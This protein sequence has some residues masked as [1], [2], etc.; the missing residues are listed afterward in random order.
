MILWYQG[1]VYPPL[2]SGREL[3]LGPVSVWGSPGEGQLTA[4][5]RRLLSEA[6]TS[7]PPCGDV[8]GETQRDARPQMGPPRK[9]EGMTQVAAVSEGL[10]GPTDV[11][12]PRTVPEEAGA[13]SSLFRKHDPVVIFLTEDRPLTAPAYSP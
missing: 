12:A 6:I 4:S 5:T 10:L 9:R 13:R 11:P 1:A 8:G 3:P 7:P 2:L